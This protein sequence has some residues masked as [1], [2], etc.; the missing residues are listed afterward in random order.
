MAR[1]S[2]P[3]WYFT[4][5]HSSRVPSAADPG[6]HNRW[7]YRSAAIDTLV[8]RGRAE[9]D[10]EARRAIYGEVQAI[11]ADE[12]PIIPLWHEDNV[13]V[14]NVD[15]DGFVLLPNA[16]LSGLARASKD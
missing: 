6:A 9:A 2:E 16:R 8:E 5:F 4:Y 3:D 1:S 12:L 14:M 15:L 10:R 11:L 13:A 7:R